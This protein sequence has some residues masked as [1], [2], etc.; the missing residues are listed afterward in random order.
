MS[1]KSKNTSFTIRNQG[2]QPHPEIPAPPGDLPKNFPE[3][4]P[5]SDD[6]VETA[7]REA[8]SSMMKEG[9][10]EDPLVE[11]GLPDNDPERPRE[12]PEQQSNR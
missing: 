7:K 9:A 6:G 3:K 12:T 5:L 1:A 11:S 10:G 8:S 4:T 2:S